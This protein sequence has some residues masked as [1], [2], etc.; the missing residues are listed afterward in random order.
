MS[1]MT[2]TVRLWRWVI[3]TITIQREADRGDGT[4]RYRQT[5]RDGDHWSTS[6]HEITGDGVTTLDS[7]TAYYDESDEW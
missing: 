5:R 1:D 6:T 4:L 2:I 3:L 7:E